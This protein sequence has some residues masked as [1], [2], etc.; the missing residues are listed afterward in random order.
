MEEGVLNS[1]TAYSIISSTRP[2]CASLLSVSG[3]DCA[4]EG[5]MM[6]E[7]DRSAVCE[8]IMEITVLHTWRKCI[9]GGVQEEV[10]RRRCIGG[11][12]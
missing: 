8:V 2:V 3:F 12:V 4:Y 7:H 9:G 11:G 6:R 1:S 5:C 10:Y